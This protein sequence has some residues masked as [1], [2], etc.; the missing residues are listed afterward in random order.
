MEKLVLFPLVSYR[1]WYTLS[2]TDQVGV[3]HVLVDKIKPEEYESDKSNPSMESRQDGHLGKIHSVMQVSQADGAVAMQIERTS[4]MTPI[5]QYLY[6]SVVPVD[7]VNRRY[8]ALLD[9]TSRSVLS[10]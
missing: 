1:G 6:Q 2:T 10:L 9:R 8:R 3:R 4:P 7:R 5:E